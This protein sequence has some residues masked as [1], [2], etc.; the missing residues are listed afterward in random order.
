MSFDHKEKSH[1]DVMREAEETWASWNEVVRI[2]AFQAHD[3]MYHTKKIWSE[4][5]TFWADARR[6]TLKGDWSVAEFDSEMECLQKKQTPVWCDLLKTQAELRE[7]L[8][9]PYERVKLVNV[10]LQTALDENPLAKKYTNPFSHTFFGRAWHSDQLT[11]HNF[12]SSHWMHQLRIIK[13]EYEALAGYPSGTL[14][15]VKEMGNHYIT[16]H[17]RVIEEVHKRKGEEVKVIP[18]TGT[19]INT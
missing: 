5:K 15:R 6:K 12:Y 14:S 11:L 18:A 10:H 13:N 1:E 7:K 16:E 9:E 8:N 17:A 3:L 19:L 4:D 2:I